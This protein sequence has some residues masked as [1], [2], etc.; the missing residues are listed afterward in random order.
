MSNN[1]IQ[2]TFSNIVSSSHRMTRTIVSDLAGQT[3]PPGLSNFNGYHIPNGS[4]H[5]RIINSDR[6]TCNITHD[7]IITYQRY[8]TCSNCEN[9]YV[10]GAIKIWL[11]QRT[12]NLR[13]CPTCR[14]VWTNF[15]VYINSNNELD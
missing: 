7:D 9:N 10:E 2:P 8:M 14:E 5:Y 6:I 3:G 1:F 11:S 15:D 12:G 13:T 4:I